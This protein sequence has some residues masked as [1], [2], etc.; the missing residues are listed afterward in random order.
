M[1]YDAGSS[2]KV[3]CDNLEGLDEVGRRFKREGTWV[4]LRLM[5]VDVWQKPT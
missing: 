4:Y 1:L 2:N 3:L 5:H